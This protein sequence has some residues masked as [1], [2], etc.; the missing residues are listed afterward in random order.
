M[1][2]QPWCD[3]GTPPMTSPSPT[4]P[5]GSQ[6]PASTGQ[7]I[8]Q[9]TTGRAAGPA[10]QNPHP[11][12]DTIAVMAIDPALTASPQKASRAITAI[13][14][15]TKAGRVVVVAGMTS[16]QHTRVHDGIN[17]SVNER[18]THVDA[19]D[20]AIA[21]AV[22]DI[23][24][25]DRLASALRA[26]GA[27]AKFVPPGIAGPVTR[28]GP[29]SAEPRR[30]RGP[31]L[32]KAA[33]DAQI[34]VLAANTGIDA[35]GDLVTLGEPGPELTAAF[36]AGR[37]ALPFEI[38]T[39]GD[40]EGPGGAPLPTKARVFAQRHG[41]EYS[42]SRAADAAPEPP[43]GR[44]PLARPKS[45]ARP[46]A[47]ARKVGPPPSD[48]EVAR[49]SQRLRASLAARLGQTLTFDGREWYASQPVDE[50]DGGMP[51]SEQA[52]GSDGPCPLDDAIMNS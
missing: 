25:A 22:G 21:L 45:P 49:A 42:A 50:T 51:G 10:T 7:S 33:G 20:R 41:V 30:L 46:K 2:T 8:G 12:P 36:V 4:I 17:A 5:A 35:A 37:L 16:E 27:S 9:S 11:H 15:R 6:A 28:G 23:E 52:P 19:S 26:A 32:Y 3:E 47:S 14:Q 13:L 39:D 1:Y 44:K 38:V 40:Q 43:I 48:S 24:A 31:N 34:I 18:E 29:L